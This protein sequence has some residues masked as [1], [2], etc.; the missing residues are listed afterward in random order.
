MTRIINPYTKGSFYFKDANSIG[1]HVKQY[2]DSVYNQVNVYYLDA[3]ALNNANWN[4][5]EN[6]YGWGWKFEIAPKMVIQPSKI[7]PDSGYDEFIDYTFVENNGEIKLNPPTYTTPG[8]DPNDI[9]IVNVLSSMD[10]INITNPTLD[11]TTPPIINSYTLTQAHIRKY[12][13]GDAG[14]ASTIPQPGIPAF[15]FMFIKADAA[16]YDIL[17]Y[18]DLKFDTRVVINPINSSSPFYRDYS[19]SGI[20]IFRRTVG[21]QSWF[22]S[23]VYNNGN[24][25]E[26]KAIVRLQ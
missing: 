23:F 14:D 1:F 9:G 20:N 25:E 7:F 22:R 18:N 13:Y 19:Y 10:N 26:N 3:D 5:Y 16:P 21:I 2:I 15:S 12:V 6:D 17:Y 8:Y 4:Y 11:K 24:G